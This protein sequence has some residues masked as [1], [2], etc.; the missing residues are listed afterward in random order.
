LGFSYHGGINGPDHHDPFDVLRV[1][2]D[3]DVTFPL[4][5]ARMVCYRAFGSSFF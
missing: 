4:F 3:H 1:A 5:Q 2:V